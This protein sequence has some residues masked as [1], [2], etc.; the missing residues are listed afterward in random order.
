[1]A[2]KKSFFGKMSQRISEA[3]TGRAHVDEEFLDELEEI[4]ITSDIGMETTEKIV[5]T[6]RAEIKSNNLSK[7]E[8]I[9]T[10]LGKIIADLTDKEERQKLCRETPL[11]ILMIGINGGGKTTSIGKLAYRLK[12]EG[13]TVMLAAADTFRAAAAEQLA[14][15]ADRVGVNMIRHG[16]GADPS[17]VIYDAIQSAKAKNMDVLIC[18][19]AGRL[20]NKKNLMNE[21]N[22]MNKV[23]S[24]EFPE[25]SRENLM[26]LDATT[27]KNAVSQVKEFGEAADITGIILT[28]LDGTAK[29]GIVI[30][31]ADE[32]DMPV[33]FIG[34]G[35]G[36]ED[37]KEFDPKEFAEGIFDE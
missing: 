26:V 4:L 18:D 25:A 13:K 37:L 28:K 15:W 31:I 16:E 17:A 8:V 2:G 3:L 23:I 9:K 27:G 21:L 36:I 20:Q 22:K 34:V 29:G 10:R 14:I 7:P 19:T 30:T 1:M 6:L 12:N 5:D 33:K 32:F 35:E 24:R 11:V